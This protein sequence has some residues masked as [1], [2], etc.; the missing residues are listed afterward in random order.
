M[1]AWVKL[2]GQNQSQVAFKLWV[3]CVQLVKQIWKP[4][5]GQGAGSKPK[6]GCFQAMGQV[7]VSLVQPAPQRGGTAA[8]AA[9]R[10][11]RTRSPSGP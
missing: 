10:R 6:P 2:Q 4:H 7:C 3:N 9:R 5:M 11:A 8:T 1:A